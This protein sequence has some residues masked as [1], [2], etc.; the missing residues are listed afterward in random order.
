MNRFLR[1][2]GVRAEG[3]AKKAAG[4]FGAEQAGVAAFEQGLPLPVAYRQ[5][6]KEAP[7]NIT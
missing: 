7:S 4:G 2:V 6:L 3:G 5:L 1:P